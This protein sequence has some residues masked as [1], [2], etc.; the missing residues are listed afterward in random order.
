M[1]GFFSQKNESNL[2]LPPVGGDRPDEIGTRME[3]NRR[4]EEKKAAAALQV[5]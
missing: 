3:R 1:S 2:R 4:E 5:P